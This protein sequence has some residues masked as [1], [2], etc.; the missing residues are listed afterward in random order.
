MATVELNENNFRD[1]VEKSELAILDFWAPWCGPCRSFAPVFERVSEKFPQVLFGKINTEVEQNLASYFQIRSIP[2][3]FVIR[4]QIVLHS[5]A[6]ALGEDDLEELVKRAL[7]V[8]M[9]EVR[10]HV[11]E[12]ERKQQKS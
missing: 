1:T 7:E 4:E 5:A 9:D 6:G 8:D 12:E 2:S 10:K 3:L 11:E